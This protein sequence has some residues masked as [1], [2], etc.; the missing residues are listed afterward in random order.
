METT[1]YQEIT[2]DLFDSTDDVIGHGVNCRG[3]MSSGIAVSFKNKYPE[4][5]DIYVNLCDE[6]RLELGMVYPYKSENGQ[7]IF[8]LATQDLPGANATYEA[9]YF[10]L[11]RALSVMPMARLKTLSL[12]QIGCGVGGLEWEIVSEII[13]LL[14]DTHKTLITVYIYDK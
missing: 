5:H 8:N 9:L 14:A 13:K 6:D 3:A 2:G 4:M 7:W 11:N 12:P 1:Y 10:S